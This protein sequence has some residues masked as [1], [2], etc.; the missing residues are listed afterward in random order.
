[1]DDLDSSKTR[2]IKQVLDV[3]RLLAVTAELDPLLTQLAEAAT[4]LL[5][6]ER[7]SIF[8]H[9]SDKNELWT[10]IALQ[11]KSEIRIAADRGIVGEAFTR[12]H[13]ADCP[14]A[15]HDPRFHREFD[16]RMG[17]STRNLLAAPMRDLDGMPLG[18]VQ[19]INKK[20]GPFMAEDRWLIQLLAEQAGAAIQ[21]YRLH[22][23]AMEI[24]SLR[25]EMDMAR[26]VQEELIPESAPVIPGLEAAGK[27]VTASTTGGDCF[28]LWKTSDGRLGIL[29]ADASG[30]GMPAALV[31]SQVRTLVRVLAQSQFDPAAILRAINARLWEDLELGRFVTAFVGFLDSSG[32]LTW[33]SAGHG[34]LFFRASANSP[35]EP[36]AALL[37]PVA[38][39]ADMAS[40][41][42]E[43]FQ[44]DPGGLIALLS[45]GILDV[46]TP[47]Q[48]WLGPEPLLEALRHQSGQK[49]AE[50]VD[51]LF[52]VA[53][54]WQQR[55]MPIDDQTAVVI[56]RT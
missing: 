39:A 16:Q 50:I 43:K 22:A 34:P 48:R 46:R 21:N 13:V 15:A 25:R 5:G 27:M 2:Q 54:A 41:P 26:E 36:K 9:D 29:L 47:D 20:N 10:K 49:P 44:M 19:A 51:T 17:F 52:E 8:L 55:T 11:A 3:S 35:V 1:M 33:S 32:E 28:D 40:I 30:H 53:T 42:P 7:A 37:P 14:D 23:T 45:D 4:S 38:C 18:V 56:T 12:N 31:V 6:C 24:V